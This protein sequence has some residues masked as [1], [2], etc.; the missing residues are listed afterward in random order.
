[1]GI[2]VEITDN[3]KEMKTMPRW[4]IILRVVIVYLFSFALVY[5]V[6]VGAQ[7]MFLRIVT[8]EITDL[9]V[10][11]TLSMFIAKEIIVVDNK[12]RIFEQLSKRKAG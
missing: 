4:Q 1:M 7:H 8:M 12:L 10:A 6:W 3:R 9:M 2:P 5:L 11:S